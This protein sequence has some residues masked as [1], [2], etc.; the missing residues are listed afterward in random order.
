MI[1]T[2]VLGMIVAAFVAGASIFTAPV[3]QAIAAVIATDVQC[4]GCV[5]SSD[6]ATS[7]VTNSKLNGGSVTNAKL[8]DSAVTTSKIAAGGVS[9]SDVS[10]SFMK[11]VLLQDNSAGHTAGWDPGFSISLWHIF[12]SSVT[13]NS[14]ILVDVDNNQNVAGYDPSIRCASGNIPSAGSFI[15]TCDTAPTE[16]SRLH[17]VVING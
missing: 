9:S 15:M 17:Y 12:D 13:E 8:G 2:K 11:R 4:T 14:I 6:L 7:A 5:G 3:Q 16:G 1:Q 10:Q